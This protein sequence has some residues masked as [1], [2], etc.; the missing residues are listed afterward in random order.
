[1]SNLFDPSQF[2][3]QQGIPV[4]NGNVPAVIN[5]SGSIVPLG[6]LPTVN[7][8]TPIP[9]TSSPTQSESVLS[10]AGNAL[11]GMTPF[12][13]M[14]K[15][16]SGKTLSLEDYVFIVLGIILIIGGVFAFRSTQNVIEVGG[17]LAAKAAATAA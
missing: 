17:K 12:G 16:S 10:K 2:N 4:Y 11:L 3:A 15:S 1:M 8:G 6:Q 14:G 7:Y 5:P 9:S 13:I